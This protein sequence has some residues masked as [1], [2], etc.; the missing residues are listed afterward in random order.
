MRLLRGSG[1][2]SPQSAR[3]GTN[4]QASTR[5]TPT[6][7]GSI[8]VSAT[9]D[10]VSSATTFTATAESVPNQLEIYSGN[11]QVGELNRL[12]EEP[13]SVRLLDRDGDPIQ[14]IT[15]EFEITEGTGRL[16]PRIARTDSQGF[17]EANLTPRSTGP[18]A[19]EAS[20]RGID[21]ISPVTFDI[22]GGNPPDALILVSGNNQSGTPGA[23]LGAPFV[24]EVI[25]EDDV[26][27][28]GV[29]VT[30][31][32]L[33]GGGTLSTRSATTGSNGRAQAT[34]TLGE[35]IGDN[36][37]EARVSGLT[38]R[39]TFRAKTGAQV[40]MEAANRSPL[41]WI[42]RAKG[43]L[44]RLVGDE[45]EDLAPKTQGVTCLAVDSANGFLYFAVQQGGNSG[46]VQRSTLNGQNVQ[47]LESGIRVPSSIAVDA[48]GGTLYWTAGNGKIKSM[49]AG[50]TQRSVTLQQGLTDPIGIA[51][52]NGYLYWA[53][54]LGRI[55][56]VSLTE[57]KPKV[58]N[59]ATGLGEPISTGIFK[60][61]IYWIEVSSAGTGRLQRAN[62]D[63]SNIE[64]FKVFQGAVPA[65]MAIDAPD[66]KIYWTKV[67]KIQR[68]NFA[69]VVRDVA[70]GLVSPGMIAVGVAAPADDPVV[71]K[72]KQDQQADKPTEQPT[73]QPKQTPDKKY[74]VNGDG[75][76]N[77]GDVD[78]VV[79]AV[80]FKSSDMKYDVNGDG[81]VNAMDIVAI[82]AQV[83]GA[84]A[85]PPTD[86]DVTLLDVEVLHEQIALLLASGDRSVAAKQ[87]LAYLQHLLTL[88]RPSETVL[89]ANYPNPFNPETWIPY[90]LASATDVKINIY[91]AQ[92]RLVRALTLGH[93][94]AGYYTHRSRAAYWDGRNAFGEQVASGIYFYQLQ[95]DE[96][97]SLRKMVILK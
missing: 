83:E 93:Q 19:V 54:S 33:A 48:A 77:Q 7:S 86:V 91:D 53:E 14:G 44:H 35:A 15:I 10:G 47:T 75:V 8:T 55:S 23:K 59:I 2:L 66:R 70:T 92:G 84:A 31:A 90:H 22:S 80:A 51:V 76:V 20:V 82:T 45:I 95:T 12:L 32:V 29:T 81:A 57:S 16:V 39:V 30:F 52:S 89:L 68:S 74:D 96:M 27:M 71:E 3:T 21:T 28:S 56:R 1:T 38:D 94:T 46:A 61:K 36:T 87:T 85:A 41:Y 72:P 25:D 78:T 58:A 42:D 26:P 49:P 9:V 4:G 88:A 60:G 24:V 67:D 63:G 43:T 64:E 17:A 40:V 69:G 79:L 73:E 97:S 37:V 11:D 50:G 13:L 34:L 62:V 5:L 65:G 18:I 6:A